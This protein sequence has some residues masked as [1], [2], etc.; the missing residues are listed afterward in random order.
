MTV[1][2]IKIFLGLKNIDIQWR[3]AGI[4]QFGKSTKYRTTWSYCLF[5]DN[6][7][8]LCLNLFILNY[9]CTSAWG[10]CADSIFVHIKISLTVS[11]TEVLSVKKPNK[12]SK[13]EKLWYLF[14][15]IFWTSVPKIYSCRGDWTPGCL[16]MKFLDFSNVS[17]GLN[18]SKMGMLY[19]GYH[20]VANTSWSRP[21][22]S[23]SH[24]KASMWR[25][26]S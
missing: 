16:P 7:K 22:Q 1:I 2:F 9:F 17:I 5:F 3:V 14:L 24:K 19:G 10:K 8:C 15:A 4:L 18:L 12:V 20:V 23:S 11:V 26:L 21:N 25:T 6:L 13:T